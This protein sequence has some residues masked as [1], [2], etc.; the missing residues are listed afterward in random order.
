MV[1]KSLM[2]SLVLTACGLTGAP[3]YAQS[4]EETA[5]FLFRSGRIETPD[6]KVFVGKDA[7]I[8][9]ESCIV[10][11]SGKIDGSRFG[12]YSVGKAPNPLVAMGGHDYSIRIDFNKLLPMYYSLN[13]EK[14]S[15]VVRII[16][17][18]GAIQ[19]TVPTVANAKEILAMGS[20]YAGSPAPEVRDAQT[21]P[22]NELAVNYLENDVGAQRLARLGNA[23]KYFLGTFCPGKKSAY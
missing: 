23:F 17:E 13:R 10:T 15:T 11:V 4:R 3:A 14:Y 20:T 7:T 16:G 12:K 1:Q 5:D 22:S 21:V 6:L 8:K 18:E 2:L 19:S 9:E